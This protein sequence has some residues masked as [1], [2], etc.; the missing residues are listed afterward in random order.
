[1]KVY[2]CRICRE[3]YLGDETPTHCPFCG[4]HQRYIIDLESA[5]FNIPEYILNNIS[6]HNLEQALELEV[7]NA[8]FYFCAADH[9]DN[10]HDA[11]MFN[12]LAKIESEHASVITK[13]L[14]I[15]PCE[16]SR[17]AFTC[18]CEN[19][20]NLRESHDLETNAI[21]YYNQFLDVATEER[22]IEVFTALIEIESD[23]LT[24]T[25]GRF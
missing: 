18:Y 7:H 10:M 4:A 3:G 13:E 12:R 2:K 15:S 24:L 25:K 8:E 14:K 6:R 11:T 1:M 5:V 21:D 9:A 19:V 23:H 22:V 16:T 17:G 20:Y